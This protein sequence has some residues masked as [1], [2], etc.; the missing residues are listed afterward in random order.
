MNDYRYLEKNTK[1]VAEKTPNTGSLPGF[2]E[3]PVFTE[4]CDEEENQSIY[5]HDNHLLGCEVPLKGR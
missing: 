5:R 1:A 3:E 2:N 4:Q